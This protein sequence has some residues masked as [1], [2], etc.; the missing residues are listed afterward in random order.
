MNGKFGKQDDNALNKA[1]REAVRKHQANLSFSNT[2]RG[3]AR[4]SEEAIAGGSQRMEE[5]DDYEGVDDEDID[6]GVEEE[7]VYE[8][9]EREEDVYEQ[10]EGEYVYEQMEVEDVY[11]RTEEEDVCERM[12]EADVCGDGCHS[13]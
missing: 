2:C 5:E 12:E 13:E 10:M 1:V 8:Q 11:E 9:I 6:E 4:E 7:D 3:H